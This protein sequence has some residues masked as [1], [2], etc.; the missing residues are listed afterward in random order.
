MGLVHA[1]PAFRAKLT[2]GRRAGYDAGSTFSAEVTAV[3]ISVVVP[4]YN[5]EQSLLPLNEAL[6]RVL[7]GLGRSYEIV[8]VDDG[9]TD[10]SFDR[11]KEIA[12]GSAAVRAIRFRRNFGKAAALSAGFH[13]A[14]GAVIITLDADLQDDPDEIPRLLAH[15]DEGWDLVSGWKLNR[16]DPLSKTLPS[17]IFNGVTGR[18]SGLKLHDFN[19]GFK[20]YRTE[21]VRNLRIYGEL[22]RYVP[23]LAHWKGFRVSE[24]P[25]RHHPRA[26]GQSKYGLGRFP[27]GLVDLLTVMFLTRF[28]MRPLHLFGGA[29][30]AIG[31]VGF[32]SDAYLSVLWMM[33][34]GIGQRPLLLMGV[35][36]MILG[37]NLV[38][39]GLIGEMIASRSFDAEDSFTVKETL[40]DPPPYAASG[41]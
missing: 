7:S 14:R 28:T 4:L 26:Y 3:D 38:S 35:L 39:M 18:L 17:R 37:M 24:L 5:E 22:H 23:V 19:C 9:S 8:Y 21:V 29:G 11:L 1:R 15:L 33:G 25:V 27:K 41:N 31:G 32:V 36:C 12:K 10:A 2:W 40:G 30:L 34:Y 13:A 16:Q 6:E 20:V